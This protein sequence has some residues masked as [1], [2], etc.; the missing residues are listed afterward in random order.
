MAALVSADVL[1]RRAADDRPL[2]WAAAT[3]GGGLVG[4]HAVEEDLLRE[5]LDR[6]HLGRD[7]FVARARAVEEQAGDHLG[8]LLGQLGVAIDAGEAAASGEQAARAARTAFVRL[9]DEGLVVEEDRVV[10]VCPRCATV[11]A[12]ADAVAEDMPCEVPM[13]RLP[14]VGEHAGRPAHLDV[15]C[16]SP[17][18]LPGV[19]AVAVPHAHPAGGAS[20]A[21]PVTAVV[22][23]VLADPSVAEPALVVPAHD[24]AALDLARRLGL[25]VVP[26]VDADGTVGAPGP[27][28][29]LARYAARA[30]A[31]RLL[32]AEA[33]VVAVEEQ[34]ERAARCRACGTVLVPRLGRHWFLC[35]AE[36]VPAAA[37]AIRDGHLAVPQPAVRE[38]LLR[39]ARDGGDWCLSHQLWTG[40]PVPVVRCRDCA[41]VDVSVEPPTSCGR[42]MGDLIAD[43]DVLDARFVRCMWPLAACGWPGGTGAP[44]GGGDGAGGVLLVVAA[45]DVDDVLPMVALGLR[46]TGAVPFGEVAVAPSSIAGGG[47]DEACRAVVRAVAAPFAGE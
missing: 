3:V 28:E 31:R 2:A 15:R 47:Y 40:E 21:V 42:C 34:M 7:G 12:D 4:Q 26:V 33:A 11:V 30:A 10:D 6:A 14:L 39:R 43:H 20:A 18:L 25:S 19:V 5:G 35:M 23:P 24:A 36:L 17:E 38:D 8:A 45:D 1:V 32:E 9:F 37:D 13:V 16:A 44:G 41:Q 22:V 29:G 27:L 46:L